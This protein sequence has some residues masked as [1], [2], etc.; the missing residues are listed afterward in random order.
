[1]SDLEDN[2]TEIKL[3]DG[4]QWTVLCVDDEPNVLSSLRRLF[5]SS[6][7]RFL[8][9]GSGADALA[10]LEREAEAVDLIIS[11]MRMPNMD[12]AQL[13]AEV[14]RR[15]PRIIRMVLTGYA[16][17]DATVSSINEGQIYR[18]IN[19]PWVDNDVLFSVRE[20]FERLALEREKTRLEALTLQQ[21]ETLRE[22]N[23]SLEDK[24][25]ERTEELREANERLKRGFLMSVR[26]FSNL[27]E[28]RGGHVGGHSRRVA[29]LAR[30]LAS[31]LGCEARLCNDIFVAAL[32]HDI[33]MIGLP[34]TL[35]TTPTGKMNGEQIAA[36]RKHPVRGEQAL[37]ALDEL[38]TA[39]RIIRSHHER[40]DGQGFPDSLRGEL[41][42]LGARILALANDYDNLCHGLTTGQRFSADEAKREIINAKNKRY[43][44]KV[45]DAFIV[46]TGAPAENPTDERA[47]ATADLK[48]GMVLARDLISS[49]GALLL[50]TDYILTEGVVL[51]IQEYER[52]E[53]RPLT[54][55]VRRTRLT[56]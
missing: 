48:P 35:L 47:I 3:F 16:D 19:K 24:V 1:M 39:A 55:Y 46:L 15:W 12:G 37:M 53:Q 52:I 36:Y 28:L 5:R 27:I 40:Y 31:A 14:R 20:A 4:S 11:D 6:G 33:G 34:D 8:S 25:R 54:L 38:R 7:Y 30:K 56:I 44:P 18:Y 26:V 23:A 43:D 13:L 45:V 42:P 9:A 10:L 2:P 41:I 51:Q 50:A 29:D 17:L 21:N 32:L 49:D 22:L